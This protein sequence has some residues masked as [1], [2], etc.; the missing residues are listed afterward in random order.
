MKKV[1]IGF[2]FLMVLASGSVYA[3]QETGSGEVSMA[4]NNTISIS[5]LLQNEYNVRGAIDWFHGREHPHWN[6]IN[7]VSIT[8]GLKT[9]DSKARVR[10]TNADWVHGKWAFPGNLS[11]AKCGWILVGENMQGFDYR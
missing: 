3:G 5:P 9:Y 7:N 8:R 4:G 6:V 11:Q 1:L 2:A 10:N